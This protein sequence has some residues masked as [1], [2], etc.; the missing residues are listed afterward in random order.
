MKLLVDDK[1]ANKEVAIK[2]T[3]VRNLTVFA[4]AVVQGYNWVAQSDGRF[5]VGDT[6]AAA[7]DD[8]VTRNTCLH[9]WEEMPGEPPH[10]VC[11]Q[12][13]MVRE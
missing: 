11:S 1:Y 9:S 6:A 2:L 4:P 10:D 3:H 13:G 7:L 8:L 5:G 12:C